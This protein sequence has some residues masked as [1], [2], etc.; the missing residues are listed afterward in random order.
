MAKSIEVTVI[1]NVNKPKKVALVLLESDGK[2]ERELTVPAPR[3]IV[4]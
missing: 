3:R 4:G 2:A 1:P